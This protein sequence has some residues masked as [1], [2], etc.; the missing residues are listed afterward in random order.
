MDLIEGGE[1]SED[2]EDKGEG[3]KGGETGEQNTRMT[4]SDRGQLH[5]PTKYQHHQEG[6]KNENWKTAQCPLIVKGKGLQYAPWSFLDL[7]GLIQWLPSLCDGGKKWITQFKEK[8]AGQH[9]AIGDIKAILCHMVGKGRVEDI[10]NI[11][12]LEG[13]MKDP[14]ND[15]ITFGLY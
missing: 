2:E 9:L 15:P 4:I 1:G 13:M 8:M 6:S 12:S 5:P 3:A 11:A 10:M 7:T 14:M